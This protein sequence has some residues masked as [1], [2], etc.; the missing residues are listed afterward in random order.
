M[1]TPV[2]PRTHGWS[3]QWLVRPAARVLTLL[4]AAGLSWLPVRAV[5]GTTEAASAFE[6]A[7]RLYERGLYAEAAEAY[8]QLLAR[9]VRTVAVLYNRGN[10]WFKTGRLGRAIAS[11]REAL[12]LAPRDPEILHNLRFVRD[13]VRG[14]SL[15]PGLLAEWCN[16]LSINEWTV[17]ALVPF[18][19]TLLL[20]ATGQVRPA[21]RPR[22]GPWVLTSGLA[23]LLFA[24]MVTLAV[25]LKQRQ[26]LAV[27]IVNEATVHNGPFE[28]SPPLFSLR[29]GSE[30]RVL[31]RK[32]DWLR[33]T[34]DGIQ[35]GW[36]HRAQVQ[37][38]G[39]VAPS[40]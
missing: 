23:T 35:S 15:R 12:E 40:A 27:V 2:L 26:P 5:S 4:A 25:T 17:L 30:L 8:E 18:W 24:G 3:G 9:G 29:D 34:A 14:P 13:Q 38:L 28:E 39:P 37:W 32:G 20:L 31:D 7:N 36:I 22:L 33:V 6:E 1:N 19:I 21:W 10:A 16:R 11:Y